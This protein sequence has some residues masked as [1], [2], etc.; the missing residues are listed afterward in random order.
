[1]SFSVPAA[2]PLASLLMRTISMGNQTHRGASD[3]NAYF[4]KQAPG[5]VNLP[6]PAQSIGL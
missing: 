2:A 3:E 4:L 5:D 6:E 1:M